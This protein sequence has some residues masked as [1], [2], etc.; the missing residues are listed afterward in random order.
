MF[1]V[2]RPLAL[3]MSSDSADIP[4]ATRETCLALNA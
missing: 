2:Q 1:D 3:G 4:A